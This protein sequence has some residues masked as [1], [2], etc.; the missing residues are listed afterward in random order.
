[1]HGVLPSTLGIIGLTVAGVSCRERRG[2]TLGLIH[3]APL[4]KARFVWWKVLSTAIVAVVLLAAPIVRLAFE[5]P[6]SLASFGV[7]VLAMVAA[8]TSLGI[9]SS[10]PKTFVVVFLTCMY[11]VAS[12]G[13]ASAALDFAGFYEKA[14]LRVT[15]AYALAAVT[16][17]A[18]AQVAYGWRLRREN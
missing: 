1:M 10:T 18:L 3:A 4:L 2:G 12:D 13:G 5:S 9:I 6:A 7:G 8:A 14:T 17:L 15:L 11:V 16:F